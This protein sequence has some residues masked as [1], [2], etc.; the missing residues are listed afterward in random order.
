MKTGIT[1]KKLAKIIWAPIRRGL[2]WVL[3]GDEPM[4]AG[5]RYRTTGDG[6]A[7]HHDEDMTPAQAFEIA[8]ILYVKHCQN[9]PAR[10]A[11]GYWLDDDVPTRSKALVAIAIQVL[12]QNHVVG[13]PMKLL[14]IADIAITPAQ[15]AEMRALYESAD[16]LVM[17]RDIPDD[18]KR[19]GQTF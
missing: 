5:H 11:Q 10:R 4:P 19:V 8:C 13:E 7:W 2:L 18:F 17:L 3:G 15:M 6:F 14:G 12:N 1:M 16:I 9:T